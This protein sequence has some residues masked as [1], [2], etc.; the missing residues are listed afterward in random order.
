MYIDAIK[1][2]RALRKKLVNEKKEL[3]VAEFSDTL[4]G[5]DTS[6]IVDLQP[7][8]GTEKY[9]LRTKVN[10]KEF[11]FFA[12]KI[13]GFEYIN[14]MIRNKTEIENFAKKQSF[15]FPLW[16]KKDKE[17]DLRKINYYNIPLIFQVAG[18]NFHNGSSIGGC[19][20]CFVDDELN[21]GK[22][23]KNKTYL[24]INDAF[25]T[26]VTTKE[27]FQEKYIK[28]NFL[29]D[30][31]LVRISGGEPSIAFDW[32]L[33]L[34]E[35]LAKQNLGFVGSIDT[36]LSTGRLIDEFENEEVFEKYTLERLA[37]LNVTFLGAIKGVDDKNLMG[38]VNAK[39]SIEEQVYSIKKMVNA[40]ANI[41]FQMYNPNPNTLDDYLSMMDENIE[42][43]TLRLHIG[44]L[45]LYGP[46]KQRLGQIAEK[47]GIESE[48]YLTRKVNEW[49]RNYSKGVEILSDYI[50][51]RHGVEY[52]EVV[53]SDVD[54]KVNS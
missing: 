46:N 52:K 54:L 41:F 26:L 7:I 44:D 25:N 12:S 4:I 18:C 27:K 2:A 1:R 47:K 17:F 5:K 28:L 14:P 16:F 10:I 33:K 23:A 45:K 13:E 24:S 29:M 9:V 36:N 43:F 49:D 37:E 32:S 53:R 30:P 50:R 6:K 35:K 8:V 51:K 48:K 21:N 3:L 38:N 34:F 39:T 40:K 31:R 11:D 42:N 15:D 19:N 22:K 20:Y